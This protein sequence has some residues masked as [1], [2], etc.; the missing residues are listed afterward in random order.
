M[1]CSPE[2]NLPQSRG[3]RG[4]MDRGHYFLG[5]YLLVFI[6][7]FALTGLLLNH[8][9]WGLADMQ[10]SRNTTTTEHTV[11]PLNS[12]TP[13]SDARELMRQLNLSGEI[14]WLA[15]KPDGSRFDFRVTRPGQSIEVRTD[16]T[17][18]TATVVRTQMNALGITRALHAFTGVRL[19][20]SR[21]E[22]DWLVTKIW[23]FAM[24]AVALGLLALVGSGIWLWFKSGTSQVG[25][26]IALAFGTFICG[27]FVFGIAALAG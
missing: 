14:Q 4:W 26:W 1:L 3:P 10:R 2:D 20:D 27:W 21:N 19:N 16:L 6:W 15:T 24:D 9:T 7:L 23:T 11:V 17:V 18:R 8:S 13:L 5:L 12:S 22:R 25:G